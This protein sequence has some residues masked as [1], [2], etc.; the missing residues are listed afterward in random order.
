MKMSPAA[1]NRAL[2]AEI[3]LSWEEGRRTAAELLEQTLPH[4]ESRGQVTDLVLGV[5]RNR[6][7]LDTLLTAAAE[8]KPAF[9][10]KDLM[11][12][13]RL[14]AYELVFCPDTADYAILSE[15]ASLA[16]RQARRRGFVNAV[17]RRLQRAIEDRRRPEEGTDP[18]CWIPTKI[19][20]GCLLKEPLLPEPSTQP[21]D[22]YSTVFS[23]P[24][25]LVERWLQDYD[26]EALRQICL[27]SN[28]IPSIILQPNTL[29]T[30]A[31]R[32]AELLKSE[33]VQAELNAEQTMLRIH[34]RRYLPDLW[35]FQKGYFFVQD[36]T[37]AKTAAM[38]PVQP[39]SVVLDLCAAPGGKTL[40][41]AMMMKNQGRII[42]ADADSQRLRKVEE[43]CRRL[44][45]TCVQCVPPEQ[46]KQT[47]GAKNK[48]QAV[49][50]DVPC[51]NT[52]VMARRA[53]VR[54][55]LKPET[56]PELVQRQKDLLEQA[57]GW[58]RKYGL[59]LYSTCSILPEENQLLVQEFLRNRKEFKLEKEELTL[60]FCGSKEVF[61]HDGGYAA[62][63]RKQ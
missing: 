16:G 10:E 17:L 50:L 41:L 45:I 53:E 20:L 54:W 24:K 29:K 13:L 26:L 56:I 51:S 59:L 3:L 11:I 34:T 58:V 31:P 43:N 27:A 47:L 21:A 52:G 15:T 38:L 32:L 14:G 62:L 5:I 55:R 48:V 18:R 6:T 8:M 23:M 36:P 57:A 7:L 12:L 61:A 19:P 28:R 49:L 40:Q 46:I 33:A 25:W 63:L 42:A 44:E 2:A 39:G 37:A 60:P 9:I 22:Y 35:T 30:T 1:S 4:A